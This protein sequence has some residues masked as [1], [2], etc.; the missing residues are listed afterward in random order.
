MRHVVLQRSFIRLRLIDKLA[1]IRH[2]IARISIAPSPCPE[3]TIVR[4]ITRRSFLKV[5]SGT[6]GVCALS[7]PMA[8]GFAPPQGADAHRAKIYTVYFGIAPSQDDTDL[9]PTTNA[10]ITRRLQQERDGVDFV[11]R[12]LTWDARLEAVLNEARDLK[13][14]DYDGVIIY[15]WPRDYAL[16]RTGLPT[17]NLAV[18]KDFMNTPYPLWP[19][20]MPHSARR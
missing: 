11:V 19:R 3:E 20:S 18:I 10:E 7:P 4:A 12:D 14:S 16:L 15:G 13:K 2:A 6:F 8:A 9:K 5:S 1:R 17:I